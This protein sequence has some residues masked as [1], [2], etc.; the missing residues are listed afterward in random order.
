MYCP[1]DGTQ[2]PVAY[3]LLRG[4][5]VEYPPCP[6][7]G[8]IWVCD[9][10]EGCYRTL[11][12][13]GTPRSYMVQNEAYMAEPEPGE[14]LEA[15][16]LGA[17]GAHRHNM[18]KDALVAQIVDTMEKKALEEGQCTYYTGTFAVARET[19]ATAGLTCERV[20]DRDRHGLPPDL[21]LRWVA[22]FGDDWEYLTKK[23]AIQHL[24]AER[25]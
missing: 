10:K 11:G 15:L 12:D 8:V 21:M 17:V 20:N 18:G 19:L 25:S 16:N 7:C 22:F 13:K 6:E 5:N 24:L 1:E 14:L 9:G 23:E 4:N 3:R 2:I